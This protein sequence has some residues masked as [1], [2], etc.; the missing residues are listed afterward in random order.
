MT[1]EEQSEAD[2]AYRNFHTNMSWNAF[3]NKE[4]TNYI[5]QTHGNFIFCYGKGRNIVA[6]QL[7]NESFKLYTKPS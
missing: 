7:T 2:R 3:L 4:Q 5:F 6:E 1:L